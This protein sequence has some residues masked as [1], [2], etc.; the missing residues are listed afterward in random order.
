MRPG[1]SSDRFNLDADAIDLATRCRP[2][3]TT[4][5]Q[6]SYVGTVVLSKKPFVSLTQQIDRYLTEFPGD[7][8]DPS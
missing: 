1:R 8:A 2:S 7:D 4:G 6:V 3:F 5:A